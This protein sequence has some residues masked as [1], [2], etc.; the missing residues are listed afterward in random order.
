MLLHDLLGG[1]EV[2]ERVGNTD[3]EILAVNHDSRKTRPGDLFCC[4]S[5]A[6]ADGHRFAREAVGSG[7]TALVVE[8]V[9]P[10][11]VPQ[12]RVER[13]RRVIGPISARCAGDP[14]HS[15]RVVGVTGTN[16]KTTTTH[17]VGAIARAAGEEFGVIGTLTA[18]RT[19]PEAPELQASLSQM[20]ERGVETVAMEVSSHALAQHRV[21]GT[22]Y[23]AVGFTNLS[24][25]H[26]DYHGD[27]DAY[28]HAKARLFEPEFCDD[29]AVNLDDPRG[30]ELATLA[31]A[32]GLNVRTFALDTAADLRIEGIVP[33]GT[34]SSA[35]LVAAE[36]R[37][38]IR[39]ALPG[40][41]N[42]ENA[43]AA[44]SMALCAG[45][46]FG[47]VAPGLAQASPI[48]GRMERIVGGQPF[49]V[50]IDYA[51]TP[52]AL[53]K[54]LIAARDLAGADG[55]VLLVFGCGGDRDRGKRSEMGRIAGMNADLVVVTSDNPRSE[56]PSSIAS[57]VA[58]GVATTDARATVELD[59]RVAIRLVMGE[60]GAGDV[61]LIAG[62]GHE[63]GQTTGTTTVPFDDRVV[64]SEELES[65]AWM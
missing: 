30:D 29:A 34:G 10:L 1:V 42:L 4:I 45:L 50:L 26:L 44:A 41:F 24:R 16:G 11:P 27:L 38:P 37:V 22:R 51:H 59:R 64:A 20:R 15:M 31:R 54:V 40:R 14:S 3:V 55:R 28:F 18:E 58:E 36:G 2:L 33:D 8:R 25:D 57:A 60:A 62:K 65:V 43:A 52:G 39:L 56:D 13:V 48:A 7:A 47:A 12:I 53:E 23:A 5:G 6:A 19:T 21:D 63:V 32:A 49:T 35:T 46:P 17:L 9:L 61:V